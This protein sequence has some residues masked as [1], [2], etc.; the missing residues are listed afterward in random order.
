MANHAHMKKTRIQPLFFDPLQPDGSNYMEWST[1][2]RTYL[3]AEELNITLV[4]NPEEE[5][6]TSYR[7]QTLLILRRHIDTSL[8]QQY[9]QME[10]P[11]QLWKALEARFKH[12]D[13]LPSTSTE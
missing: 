7:W 2:M 8:R 11:V 6:P 9:V 10:N 4:E 3:C 12:K 13:H 1:D 5:I